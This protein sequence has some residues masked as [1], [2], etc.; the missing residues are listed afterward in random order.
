MS[1][2]AQQTTETTLPIDPF[3]DVASGQVLRCTD[4]QTG[5]QWFYTREEGQAIKYHERNDYDGEPVPDR[6][7]AATVACE[8]VQTAAISSTYLRVYCGGSD[9]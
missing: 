4:P 9:E 7:V 2:N 3:A 1:T 5:W 8:D 6:L